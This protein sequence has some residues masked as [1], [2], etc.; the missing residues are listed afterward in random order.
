MTRSD[1]D[2]SSNTPARNV[3]TSGGD[4]NSR[5]QAKEDFGAEFSSV[6]GYYDPAGSNA[7][8]TK[9]HRA[10][11]AG[12]KSSDTVDHNGAG[13]TAYSDWY[14][15]DA[16]PKKS[17]ESNP[18]ANKS[19][20]TGPR[21]SSAVGY[22]SGKPGSYTPSKAPPTGPRNVSGSN[23]TGGM[24]SDT[25]SRGH[26]AQNK[27]RAAPSSGG[28]DSHPRS[29]LGGGDSYRPNYAD[30]ED[31]RRGR[32]DESRSN[33]RSP[34]Y[35]DFRSHSGYDDGHYDSRYRH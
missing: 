2:S 32:Y 26:S 19:P 4:L 17:G 21:N 11:P 1:G 6:S 28:R 33:R 9:P 20:P 7:K 30:S 23:N 5:P 35:G 16:P 15:R 10:E 3:S 18:M 25:P 8:I 29:P 22:T 24:A 14:D 31:P 12:Y 13:S 27:N 34:P